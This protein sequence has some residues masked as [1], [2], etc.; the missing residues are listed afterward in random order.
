MIFKFDLMWKDQVSA[1]VELDTV[2]H[3]AKIEH[4]E[5]DY[6]DNPLLGAKNY[7]DVIKFLE[8]RRVNLGRKRRFL[9]F[10][11]HSVEGDRF[12]ELQDT[13]GVNMND[14][15]WIRFEDDTAKWEDITPRRT[16]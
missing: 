7:M 6:F 9:H 11:D 16:F 13:R 8:R 2:A 1:S 15:L 3:T 5:E 14:F 10:K 4:F 12:L